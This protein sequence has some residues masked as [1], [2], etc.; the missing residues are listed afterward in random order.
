MRK[1]C[2][3]ASRWRMRRIMLV[4]SGLEP[5]RDGVGDYCR[6]LSAELRRH[7]IDC[8]VLAFNDRYAAS[9]IREPSEGPVSLIRLPSELSLTTRVARTR[10]AIAGFDPDWISLQ[11]V[12]YGFNRK[13]LPFGETFYLPRLFRGRRVH[14]MMHELW[15]G[16]GVEASFKNALIG[17]LQKKL[18]VALLQRLRPQLLT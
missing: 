5:G 11:F 4:C 7:G 1:H 16:L 17:V 14:V 9:E 6:R 3:S 2:G 15:V 18:V 8:L 13:G 10:L 12:S